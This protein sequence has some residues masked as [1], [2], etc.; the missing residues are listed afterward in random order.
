MLYNLTYFISLLSKN[1]H[2]IFNFLLISKKYP[3]DR[4]CLT[5]DSLDISL[6]EIFMTQILV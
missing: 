2:Q 1:H 4:K 3:N 6:A 5:R